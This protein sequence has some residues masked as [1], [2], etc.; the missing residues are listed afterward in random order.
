VEAGTDDGLPVAIAG[1]LEELAE[2]GG[3]GITPH[4]VAPAVSPTTSALI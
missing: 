3:V 1:K 2:A 4:Q